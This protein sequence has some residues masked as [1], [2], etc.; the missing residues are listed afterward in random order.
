MIDLFFL[1]FVGTERYDRQLTR[2]VQFT[3]HE[4]LETIAYILD[5]RHLW[6]NH[7]EQRASVV[8]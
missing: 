1:E 7:L 6:T 5:F 3:H 4:I 8:V 2:V